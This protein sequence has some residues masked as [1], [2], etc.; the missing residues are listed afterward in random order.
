MR[1]AQQFVIFVRRQ[2]SILRIVFEPEPVRSRF[3][4]IQQIDQFRQFYR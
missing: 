1:A 4:L 2:L 3:I